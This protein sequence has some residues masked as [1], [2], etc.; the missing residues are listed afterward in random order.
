[1]HDLPVRKKL[2]GCTDA[3]LR[4]FASVSRRYSEA[5]NKHATVTTLLMDACRRR[6]YSAFAVSKVHLQQIAAECQQ[7]RAALDVMRREFEQS[8]GTPA[9]S[10]EPLPRCLTADGI[11]PKPPPPQTTEA[12]TSA[13][14]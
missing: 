11:P 13:A 9:T 1:M 5:V 4:L 7:Y 6:D 14:L 8:N 2:Y 10:A 3:E 12:L